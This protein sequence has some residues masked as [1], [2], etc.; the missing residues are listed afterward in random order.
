MDNMAALYAQ[1][2]KVDLN[3]AIQ[4]VYSSIHTDEGPFW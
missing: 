4:G 3:G 2:Q 1:Q